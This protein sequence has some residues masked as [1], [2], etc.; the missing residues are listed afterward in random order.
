ML[1]FNIY[2]YSLRN[3]MDTEAVNRLPRRLPSALAVS[4]RL[5]ASDFSRAKALKRSDATPEAAGKVQTAMILAIAFAEAIAI[6][7]FVMALI[8]KFV[9]RPWNYSPS[10]VLDWRLL[11]AQLVNF[12]ILFTALTFFAVQAIDRALDKRRAKV[13][14]SLA[15]AERSAKN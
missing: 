11:I 8:I 1:I 4:A 10:S 7:A 14:E 9:F 12:V 13:I 2:I 3:N 6:Y 5:W 15:N